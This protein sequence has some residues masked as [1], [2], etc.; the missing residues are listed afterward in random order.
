MFAFDRLPG[1]QWERDV[2]EGS[3]GRR[4]L[5][6]AALMAIAPSAMSQAMYRCS[7]GSSTYLS[8]RPCAGVRE[9]K[10]GSLGSL[11]RAQDP[12]RLG[13]VREQQ[14]RRERPALRVPHRLCGLRPLACLARRCPRKL[15]RAGEGVADRG[16]EAGAE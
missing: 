11:P 2:G 9:G 7:S 10:L 3:W 5:M 15:D 16:A 14:N 12:A 6:L 8:D 13:A 4:W 1:E